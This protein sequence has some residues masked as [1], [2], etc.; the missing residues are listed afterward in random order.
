MRHQNY[1]H[2]HLGAIDLTRYRAQ[3]NQFNF[4]SK[5]E[6]HAP[7]TSRSGIA[8]DANFEPMD[9]DAPTPLPSP[10]MPNQSIGRSCPITLSASAGILAPEAKPSQGD[11]YSNGSY[12]KGDL[13]LP[14]E[15]KG[16]QPSVPSEK[17]KRAQ[18]RGRGKR[19]HSQPGPQAQN[20]GPTIDQTAASTSTQHQP[21][22]EYH[23]HVH[24]P[25]S[26][27]LYSSL[28]E[29]FSFHYSAFS[30]A[31]GQPSLVEPPPPPNSTSPCGAQPRLTPSSL[32]QP[33]S[34]QHRSDPNQNKPPVA[35]P[36]P[37]GD[38]S[39]AWATYQAKWEA[40]E[41]SYPT[42]IE[43]E[44]IP[45]PVR[46]LDLSQEDDIGLLPSLNMVNDKSVSGFLF[47]PK[48][49]VGSSRKKL[50]KDALKWYHPDHFE[51]M[52]VARI[53]REDEAVKENVKGLGQAVVISL[54]ALLEGINKRLK[55]LEAEKK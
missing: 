9:L 30:Q 41:K 39:L 51:R 28:P 31:Q 45:W 22:F 13:Q 33:E 20:R 47:S 26:V 35:A 16:N 23:F 32:P 5:A 21:R 4:N 43:V 7:S 54:T 52:V 10:R 3:E 24:M 12:P 2:A 37:V 14:S 6:D 55:F 19:R 34:S 40:I 27:P 11:S 48:H 17:R 50:V 8:K 53:R 38:L 46:L 49:S 42:D 15:D 18:R 29:Q 1:Y 36:S 25:G 44:Q